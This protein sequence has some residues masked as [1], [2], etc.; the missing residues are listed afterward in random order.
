MPISCV[1]DRE[2]FVTVQQFMRLR[3]I[4][5]VPAVVASASK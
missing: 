5:Q 2:R 4:G 1:A 3:D